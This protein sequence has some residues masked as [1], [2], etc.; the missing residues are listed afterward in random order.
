MMEFLQTF[1]PEG[2][3]FLS[4]FY[5]KVGDERLVFCAC[6]DIDSVHWGFITCTTSMAVSFFSRL[7]IEG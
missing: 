3:E 1:F 6:S 2:S 4:S 7:N 5:S